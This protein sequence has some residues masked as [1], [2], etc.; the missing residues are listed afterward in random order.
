M[1]RYFWMA[2]FLTVSL[3]MGASA[4]ASA[5]KTVVVIANRSAHVEQLSTAE[6][7]DLF[8][9]AET[10]FSKGAM[11]VPVV[12]RGGPV[13]EAFLREYIGKLDSSFRG[14]WRSLV[15]SGQ[16]A[17]PKNVD[18]EAAMVNYVAATPG[19]IGY[20]ERSALKDNVVVVTVK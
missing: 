2:L 16:A 9:G 11:A 4:S 17:L 14:G 10:H 13:H 12:L 18:D 1:K 3:M 19:A 15:F 5:Q 20:V 7:R 8:T 6:V